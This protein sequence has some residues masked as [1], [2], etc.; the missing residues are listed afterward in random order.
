M[1]ET[2]YHNL[3]NG[4]QIVHRKTTSPVVYVGIMVGAGTRHELPNENGMAHYIEHCV[5]KGTQH[6]TARQII[7]HIEG[8]G[9]EINAYTTKEETTFYA[10]TLRQHFR[11]TLHLLADLVLRPTFH[12]KEI[13]KELTV[14]LDEIESYNDSPSELIYD[15]FENMV[16]E[17]SSLAMPILGTK[18]TLRRISKSPDIALDWMKQH[19]RPERM[20]LFVL[21]N[22]TTQQVISAAEREFISS[23]SPQTDT[24]SA[25]NTTNNSK[26]PT[27]RTYRRHTHQTHIMLG[28][29]AYPIGHPK[30]LIMYLLNNILGGGSMSSRL[31][32][33][34]REKH[35][36]VY[37]I[38]SQAVP[39]SDTGYW[40]IYLA[41]E[42]QH[43]DPCLELCHKELK[44]LRDTALTSSQLQ[45]ALRQ[46]EGQMA[47]SAENQENN[48]LAMAKQMLYHHHAPAWQE[49][50]AKVQQITPPQLQDVAN[51]V[52]APEKIYTLLYD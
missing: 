9:G 29:H 33:S 14:I 43:K 13:D 34:L 27:T 3:S 1:Y 39:L 47:I 36:L 8:I 35:G 40:N 24:P 51:E 12:K 22:V 6:Y 45:R 28:S 44:Q 41:C 32:L 38:D 48:A 49:T 26:F 19:Y 46:L 11:T 31:Y 2:F 30:Q 42:P 5:F 20:V 4:L 18:K 7:N 21:G 23:P 16:F 10:A 37:N 50:F 25:S 52:F 15:D 17:G